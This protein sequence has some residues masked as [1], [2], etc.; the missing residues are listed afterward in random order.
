[1]LINAFKDCRARANIL[2]DVLLPKSADI[3]GLHSTMISR[4]VEVPKVRYSI[5]TFATRLS[6][7]F[8]PSWLSAI[9]R[10]LGRNPKSW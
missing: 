7:S 4:S 6:T 8:E 3:D 5:A 2:D 10:G 9:W 1:M